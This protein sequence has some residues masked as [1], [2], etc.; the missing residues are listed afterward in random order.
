MCPEKV[1]VVVNVVIYKA[2]AVYFVPRGFGVDVPKHLAEYDVAVFVAMVIFAADG[3]SEC[4]AAAK[5]K[6]QPVPLS[7][8]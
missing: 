7:Q 8:V 1:G 4:V 5:L 2:F 6:L 3:D